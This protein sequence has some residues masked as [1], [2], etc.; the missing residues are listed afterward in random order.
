MTN[1]P[2]DGR[3]PMQWVTRRT[4]LTPDVIRIWE[5]RYDVVS[6]HRASNGHRY[7]SEA[8]V[9]KLQLLATLTRA[10]HRISDIAARPAPELRRLLER[11]SRPVGFEGGA[12]PRGPATIEP[13]VSAN[14]SGVGAVEPPEA[15]VADAF[16]A[17]QAMA[18]PALREALDRASVALPTVEF[19]EHFLAPLLHR[20]GSAWQEGRLRVGEEHWATAMLRTHLGQLFER[21]NVHRDGRTFLVAAPRGHRHELGA[22]MVACVAAERG[23]RILYLGAD[24]PEADLARVAHD[25][26]ARALG[27]SM[28][29]RTDGVVTLADVQTLRRLLPADCALLLGGRGAAALDRAQLPEGVEVLEDLFGLAQWLGHLL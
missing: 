4:G 25:T 17:V 9:E 29:Q 7:Y 2:L 18:E 10:G 23:F 24:T 28:V 11:E 20:I 27:L 3:Y 22:L 6:P 13:S 16:R 12:A 14:G 15:A 8:D 1:S 5:R 26:R 19:L 21:L